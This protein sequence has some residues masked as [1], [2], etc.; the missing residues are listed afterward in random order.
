MKSLV[1]QKEFN[2]FLIIILVSIILTIVNPSFLT[3]VNLLDVIRGNVVTAILALGMTL[4]I[5]T[6]GIDVSVAAVTT[7]ITVIMGGLFAYMTDSWISVL[8]IFIIAPLTGILFGMLNGFF[9]SRI[10]IP[11][12]VVTLGTFN[13][14]TG[15]VLYITNGRY[16]NSSHLPKSFIEFSNIK[17]FGISIL[18]YILAILAILTWY[19]LKKTQI[20]RSILAIGGNRESAIRV[21]ID[22]KKVLL[23]VYGFMGF[24]SGFAAIAQTAYTKAVDPNGLLGLELMV[25]AAVV[26]GG[27]SVQGGRG[28]IHGTLLGVFLIAILE[29]GMILAHID[30]YWQ[31]VVIGAV[32]VIAVTYDQIS[33]RRQQKKLATIQVDD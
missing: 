22:Q 13:I 24:L 29:N 1:K 21:G 9:V 27:T 18:I 3:V 17:I 23:F 11:P 25:I 8:L 15:I 20:G 30:T 14:F 28:T 16:L 12:I 5:I 6:G 32:I 4:I 26:V 33:Y 19:I 31:K 7:S 2:I 10:N